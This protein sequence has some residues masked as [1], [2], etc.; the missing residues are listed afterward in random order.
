MILVPSEVDYIHTNKELMSSR[1]IV[2]PPLKIGHGYRPTKIL[3]MN[4]LVNSF[5]NHKRLRVFLQKGMKCE[6]CDR[7]GVYLI[8]CVSSRGS[9]HTDIY[10]EEFELM[11][12]DHY[13]P[14]GRGGT[15]TLNNLVP[16]CN[17]CNQRKGNRM[18]DEFI[19]DLLLIKN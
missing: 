18:P 13:I 3:D 2:I 15:N 4:E 16:C 11:T 8:E 14:R 19:A 9:K 10:T 1:L 6:Y 7:Y 12:V 5:Q 17:D